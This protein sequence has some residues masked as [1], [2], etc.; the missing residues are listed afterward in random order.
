MQ[1]M[2]IQSLDQE[3]PL[4]EETATPSSI[5]AWR[6]PWTEE[7][8]GQATAH[9]VAKRRTR[10]SDQQQ[11]QHPDHLPLSMAPRTP[12]GSCQGQDR[13]CLGSCSIHGHIP[14]RHEPDTVRPQHL[15]IEVTLWSGWPP[16][17]AASERGPSV[18]SSS[19]EPV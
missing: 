6:I 12:A 3:D 18:Y 5:L 1:E 16:N 13:V 15:L 4:K 19:S 14:N 2:Q 8:A 10:L 7:P 17:P 11:R 9:E